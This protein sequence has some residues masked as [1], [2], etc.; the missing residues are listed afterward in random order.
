MCCDTLAGQLDS[1]C[2]SGN[3]HGLVVVVSFAV[4]DAG[5]FVGVVFEVGH[6]LMKRRYSISRFQDGIDES[7]IGKIDESRSVSAL[8]CLYAFDSQRSFTFENGTWEGKGGVIS[9]TIVQ[10]SATSN[11]VRLLD[12]VVDETLLERSL[13][14]CAFFVHSKSIQI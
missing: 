14:R 13:R 6:V 3:A 2:T 11:V 12:W 1:V 7:Y 5:A 10:L 4:V 9:A 8:P